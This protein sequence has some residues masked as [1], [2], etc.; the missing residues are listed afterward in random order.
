MFSQK[1]TRSYSFGRTAAVF[2][3]LVIFFSVP[4]LAQV[5]GGTLS[6]TVSDTNGSGI[7]QAKLVIKNVATGVERTATTNGD[8]FYT[9][10]NLQSGSYEISI[11]AAGFDRYRAHSIRQFRDDRRA[12]LYPLSGYHQMVVC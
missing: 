4:T 11:T 12:G 3:I 9:T 1:T 6:G 7:P 8:G 5:A 10:V 2:L